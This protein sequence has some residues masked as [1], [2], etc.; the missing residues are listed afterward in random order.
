MLQ[1]STTQGPA[2]RPPRPAIRLAVFSLRGPPCGQVA[3]ALHR[4]DFEDREDVHCTVPLLHTVAG[5]RKRFLSDQLVATQHSLYALR[6]D[7]HVPELRWKLARASEQPY[8]DRANS[9][10]LDQERACRDSPAPFATAKAEADPRILQAERRDELLLN[11]SGLRFDVHIAADLR[12]ATGRKCP[13]ACDVEVES[14]RILW[15]FGS[16]CIVPNL[17]SSPS[18]NRAEKGM[19]PLVSIKTTDLEQFVPRDLGERFRVVPHQRDLEVRP[20]A[21]RQEIRATVTSARDVR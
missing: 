19:Q 20:R 3:R 12:S 21:V 13:E 18:R 17:V 11:H 8:G 9:R 6:A 10:N 7:A 4:L 2:Y 5:G 1:E 16:L 14:Q 15:A